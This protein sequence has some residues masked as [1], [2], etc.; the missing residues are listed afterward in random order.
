L[1]GRLRR[2]RE[3]ARHGGGIAAVGGPAFVANVTVTG[4]TVTIGSTA[5]ATLPKSDR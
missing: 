5:V 1:I 4:I 2:D 3:V